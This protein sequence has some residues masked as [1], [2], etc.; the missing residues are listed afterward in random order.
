MRLLGLH[1]FHLS[2]LK[3]NAISL[4]CVLCGDDRE[5]IQPSV[6][7]SQKSGIPAH[8]RFGHYR[9]GSRRRLL[10]GRNIFPGGSWV[11]IYLRLDRAISDPYDGDG[12]LS[13]IKAGTSHRERSFFCHSQPVSAR[14]LIRLVGLGYRWQYH[15]SR[16]RYWGNRG[17]SPHP[18][19]SAA[20]TPG[21]IG[22]HDLARL[23]DMGI[24]PT[25]YKHFP[26]FGIV[27]ADLRVVRVLSPPGPSSTIALSF[28]SSS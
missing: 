6:A 10:G 11:R 22:G 24:L 21:C 12:C 1:A 9:R 27:Y 2:L 14:I 7:V 16:C 19:S 13:L 25:N 28:S 18:P 26:L 8:S 3:G 20:S 23:A 4:G 17:R 15:R 5:H